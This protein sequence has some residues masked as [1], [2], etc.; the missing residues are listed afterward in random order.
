MKE[1]ELIELSK[2]LIT[3]CNDAGTQIMS[4]YSSG[5]EVEEIKEDGSPVT[6]ADMASHKVIVDG[7]SELKQKFPILS[8]E[9]TNSQKKE[10]SLFWLVDPLDGT[11]EFINKNGEFTVNVALIENGKPIMGIVSAPALEETFIGIAGLGA[12][13]ITKSGKKEIQPSQQ[14]LEKCR[15]TLSKSHQSE[16]DEK[17]IKATQKIFS[18][19]E[20]IPAGSSLKLC[21]VAEG[22]ADIYCR[23][24]PTY[25]WDIAAGQAIVESAGAVI[26]SLEG[27]SLNYKFD[28]QL[29]NPYFYC[30]GDPSF[31]WHSIFKDFE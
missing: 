20:I 24:G 25:Q 29:R 31:D 2:K 3:I 11:K 12:S 17:F 23:L 18:K 7:L 4:I 15:I 5:Q 28:S 27:L 26:N 14:D 1:S 8:E 30:S 22:S 9:D 19:T 6:L 10:C 21:R 13:K 16:S